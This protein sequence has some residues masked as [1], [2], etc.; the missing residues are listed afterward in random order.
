MYQLWSA[1]YLILSGMSVCVHVCIHHY[2]Y[3]ITECC[4]ETSLPILHRSSFS[5]MWSL[6]KGI[7]TGKCFSFCRPNFSWFH[8]QELLGITR[9]F[10]TDVSDTALKKLS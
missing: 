3:F 2:C 5:D 10:A 7:F 9:A 6:V 1:G 4:Y 8:S